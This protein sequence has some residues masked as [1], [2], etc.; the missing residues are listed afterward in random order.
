MI[1]ELLERAKQESID[2]IS[3]SVIYAG[4]ADADQAAGPHR[5]L[6]SVRC[7]H[8]LRRSGHPSIHLIVRPP[9]PAAHYDSPAGK[10]ADRYAWGSST[11][12]L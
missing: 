7:F 2:M 10:T 11:I 12:F 1:D 3:A 8:V 6:R 5:T 4:L 9:R